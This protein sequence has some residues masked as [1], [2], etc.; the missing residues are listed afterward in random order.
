VDLGSSH[1]VPPRPAAEVLEELTE[2]NARAKRMSIVHA[3][4][5]PTHS[6]INELITELEESRHA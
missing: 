1:Y 5:G 4:Y 2:A 3:N 6:L